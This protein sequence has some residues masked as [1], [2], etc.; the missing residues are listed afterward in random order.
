MIYMWLMGMLGITMCSSASTV[1]IIGHRGSCYDAPENTLASVNKAWRDGADLVEVDVH[2]SK[3]SRIMVMHDATTARTAGV[4]LKISETESAELRKLDVGRWKGEEFTGERIPFLEEVLATI[5]SG[6]KLLVEVKCGTEILPILKDVIGRSGKA[7]QVIIISF[8]LDVVDQSKKLMPKIPA[9]LLWGGVTKDPSTGE[10]T[11][12]S[13][14]HID[15]AI[16]KCLDGLD[17][18][19]SGITKNF[20][21]AVKKAGLLL[22]AWTVNNPGEAR[23]LIELGIDAVATDRPGWMREQISP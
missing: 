7:E 1:Q 4:D 2:L 15:T 18:H 12:H 17:M 9:L 11:E 10:P 5:P 21:D 16:S 8:N 6:R 19:Y 3:D 23:R 13:L 20:V 22:Y 14:K